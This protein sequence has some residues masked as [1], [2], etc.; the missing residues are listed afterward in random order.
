MQHKEKKVYKEQL[1]KI[2][3][4]IECRDNSV[5]VVPPAYDIT[6]RGLPVKVFDFTPP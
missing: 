4:A 2:K 3:D 6:I 5:T 1:Q